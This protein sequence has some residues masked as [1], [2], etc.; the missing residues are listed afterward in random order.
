MQFMIEAGKEVGAVEAAV[1]ARVGGGVA[2][3]LH[4]GSCEL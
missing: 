3:A 1:A 2:A 4:L